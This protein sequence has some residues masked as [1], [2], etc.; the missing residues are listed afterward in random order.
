M[1]KRKDSMA[2]PKV[3]IALVE[4]HQAN[5]AYSGLGKARG[6]KP[7]CRVNTILLEAVRH[8]AG[9]WAEVNN[10]QMA[11]AFKTFTTPQALR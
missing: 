1:C 8:A 10:P 6:F 5:F 9:T 4:E 11:Q 2:L 3:R 7:G